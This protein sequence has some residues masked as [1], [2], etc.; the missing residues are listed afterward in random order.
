MTRHVDASFLTQ[1]DVLLGRVNFIQPYT[2]DDDEPYE[3][4]LHYQLGDDAFLAELL[5]ERRQAE[6]DNPPEEDLYEEEY[7]QYGGMQNDEPIPSE[8]DDDEPPTERPPLTL[9][10]EERMN[11]VPPILNTRNRNFFVR[12]QRT[13]RSPRFNLVGNAY[14]VAPQE[15]RRRVSNRFHSV[16]LMMN[17]LEYLIQYNMDENDYV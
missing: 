15:T 3:V 1:L 12:F 2:G 5:E 10:Y 6:M 8:Y 4:D 16:T 17:D 7:D 13:F 9:E 11:T 14:S